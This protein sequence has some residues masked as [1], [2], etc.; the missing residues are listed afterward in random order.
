MNLVGKLHIDGLFE[1]SISS[2]DSITVGR[3]GHIKGVVR[4]DHLSVSGRVDAEIQCNELIIERGGQVCGLVRSRLMSIH[5]QGSFIGERALTLDACLASPQQLD[6]NHP[7]PLP[8]TQE[9]TTIDHPVNEFP[10]VSQEEDSEPPHKS[11]LLTQSLENMLG[12]VP[13]VG[14]H[15]RKDSGA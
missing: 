4:A 6:N 10:D 15:Q 7:E 11:E 2:V 8:V 14:V 12:E 3:R 13:R 1:G 5:K 9:S